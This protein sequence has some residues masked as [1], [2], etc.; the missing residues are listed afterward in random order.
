[1]P[2]ANHEAFDPERLVKDIASS[3]LNVFNGIVTSHEELRNPGLMSNYRRYYFFRQMLGDGNLSGAIHTY[4]NMMKSAKYNFTPVDGSE[5]A[6]LVAAYVASVF[7]DMS[8]SFGHFLTQ[9]MWNILVDGSSFHSPVYKVRAGKDG[10]DG[11]G[12]QRWSSEYEDYHIGIESFVN[13]ST[14]S[15]YNF[16]GL[17]NAGANGTAPTGILQNDLSGNRMMIPWQRIAYACP[18]PSDGNPFGRSILVGASEAWSNARRVSQIMNVGIERN[19]LGIPVGR[20][21]QDFMRKGATLDQKEVVTYVKK[22]VTQLKKNHQSGLLLPS[23]TDDKGNALIDIE[24]LGGPDFDAENVLKAVDYWDGKALNALS[25]SFI[26][27]SDRSEDLT[28]V[29]AQMFFRSLDILLDCVAETINVEIDKI[30]RINNIKCKYRPRFKFSKL[31]KTLDAGAYSNTVNAGLTAGALTADESL[32][33]ALREALDVESAP[34]VDPIMWSDR[35]A[36]MPVNTEGYDPYGG[37][38]LA[39]QQE[40]DDLAQLRNTIAAAGTFFEDNKQSNV[41]PTH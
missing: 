35:F 22:I 27:T 10:V 15:I 3:D 33:D 31:S 28:G 18:N 34:T 36:E 26:A 13:I 21:P 40:V 7:T 2:L 25:A 32:E 29:R 30:L 4:L 1:M 8:H 19:L 6:A 23:D 38:M 17:E 37:D 9:I 5:E 16:E 24:L 41:I 12:S 11:D 20:L 39:L 14:R